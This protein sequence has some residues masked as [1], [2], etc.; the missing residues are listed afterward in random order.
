M[1]EQEFYVTFGGRYMR[2]AHPVLGWIPDA[3]NGWITV[4]ADNIEAAR[5]LL[6]AEIEGSWCEVYTV[7]PWEGG[8]S[9]GT[10]QEIIERA[11]RQ[12]EAVVDAG[13]GEGL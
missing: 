8:R 10:L 5:E 2:E 13:K 1:S 9:I 11:N 7:P 3:V 6:A 4:S 12:R